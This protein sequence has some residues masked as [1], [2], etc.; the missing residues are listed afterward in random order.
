VVKHAGGVFVFFFIMSQ[1]ITA[2]FVLATFFIGTDSNRPFL[3]E[4]D[5]LIG[6][7]T[8]FPEATAYLASS[9]LYFGRS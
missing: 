4:D 5:F 7:G 6:Y 2:A 3:S 9:Q 1:W 8:A